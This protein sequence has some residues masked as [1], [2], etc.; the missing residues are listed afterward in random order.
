MHVS[1]IPGLTVADCVVVYDRAAKRLG[2]PLPALKELFSNKHLGNAWYISIADPQSES[3]ETEANAVR[4]RN[5]NGEIVEWEEPVALHDQSEQ[6]PMG[7]LSQ[8]DAI[9]GS[10]IKSSEPNMLKPL[11]SRAKEISSGVPLRS[12]RPSSGEGNYKLGN[13]H[14]KEALNRNS[15]ESNSDESKRFP[16]AE[17]E[18]APQMAEKKSL[19]LPCRPRGGKSDTSYG[20]KST[21][22]DQPMSS[23]PRSSEGQRPEKANHVG[24]KQGGSNSSKTTPADLGMKVRKDDSKKSQLSDPKGFTP[25]RMSIDL[26]AEQSHGSN[27][28][29]HAKTQPKT[30]KD[31]MSDARTLERM[32]ALRSILQVVHSST[33]SGGLD[34]TLVGNVLCLGAVTK[35]KKLGGISLF[36]YLG[37]LCIMH[38]GCLRLLVQAKQETFYE[39]DGSFQAA[40]EKMSSKFL[41][42]EWTKNSQEKRVSPTERVKETTPPYVSRTG[43]VLQLSN[44]L[45]D[46]AVESDV[47]LK[48]PRLIKRWYSTDSC[49]KKVVH[50]AVK[51]MTKWNTFCSGR[52]ENGRCPA[53]E[54][55]MTIV[56]KFVVLELH[57]ASPISS[58]EAYAEKD[59]CIS[60]FEDSSVTL[61]RAI[62]FMYQYVS[63]R[64]SNEAPE[65]QKA[66]A[67]IAQA[68]FCRFKQPFGEEV[69]A[70]SWKALCHAHKPSLEKLQEKNYFWERVVDPALLIEED[71]FLQKDPHLAISFLVALMKN[72]K[73]VR[74]L[75]HTE[76]KH[77]KLLIQILTRILKLF[78]SQPEVFFKKLSDI[79]NSFPKFISVV[80]LSHTILSIGMLLRK[81]LSHDSTVEASFVSA[82]ELAILNCGGLNPLK[83]SLE[84]VGVHAEKSLSALPLPGE[85]APST[86]GLAT[87]CKPKQCAFYFAAFLVSS[88]W[89]GSPD[90]SDDQDAHPFLNALLKKNISQKNLSTLYGSIIRIHDAVRPLTKK[91][92]THRNVACLTNSAD[93]WLPD[94]VNV[95][96]KVREAFL[97]VSSKPPNHTPT[98]TP[99]QP[100]TKSKRF[101]QKET[102][103]PSLK[104]KFIFGEE[105]K[106]F[107]MGSKSLELSSDILKKIEEWERER[108]SAVKCDRSELELVIFELERLA[109]FL[110]SGYEPMEESRRQLPLT[111]NEL[112]RDAKIIFHDEVKTAK[113]EVGS[114]PRKRSSYLGK[115][116]L[117]KERPALFIKRSYPMKGEGLYS[118]EVIKPGSLIGEFYGEVISKQRYAC[119]VHSKRGA[120][121]TCMS[122]GDGLVVNAGVST[123]QMKLINHSCKP[124]AEVKRCVV[125]NEQRLSIFASRQ[126][127]VIEEITVDYRKAQLYTNKSFRCSCQAPNCAGTILVPVP[128]PKK[129]Y[130]EPHEQAKK[131]IVIG[132]HLVRLGDELSK[133]QAEWENIETKKSGVNSSRFYLS[134]TEPNIK[135]LCRLAWAFVRE[136]KDGFII[137]ELHCSKWTGFT[138]SQVEPNRIARTP[139]SAASSRKGLGLRSGQ[140][141]RALSAQKKVWSPREDALTTSTPTA[142][143]PAKRSPR[144]TEGSPRPPSVEPSHTRGNG[145]HKDSQQERGFHQRREGHS[146]LPNL[147]ESYSRDRNYSIPRHSLDR[148]RS[149]DNYYDRPSNHYRDRRANNYYDRRANDYFDRRSSGY[150]ERRSIRYHDRRS[151]GHHENRSNDYYDPRSNVHPRG[152]GPSSGWEAMFDNG[153]PSQGGDRG[154]T[155]GPQREAAARTS[156]PKSHTNGGERDAFREKTDLGQ[157]N[158]PYEDTARES[159]DI[160]ASHDPRRQP[161]PYTSN[162]R[163]PIDSREGGP[164]QQNRDFQQRYQDN[165]G[166]SSHLERAPD[167]NSSPRRHTDGMD[168]Y[169]PERRRTDEF[170]G[171]GRGRGSGRGDY[172]EHYRHGYPR[173]R[174]DSHNPGW[175]R[176]GRGRHR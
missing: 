44:R 103:S 161:L 110:L 171:R 42:T 140:P 38:L 69:Q 47:I 65:S 102:I 154:R 9:H 142:S 87:E 74:K 94:F 170:Y 126:V 174:S 111:A 175:K 173:R 18:E 106:K 32:T 166:Q 160:P 46:A 118:N 31:A 62:H 72:V 28:S 138:Q 49:V 117:Q 81:I 59:L 63:R 76:D 122:L 15:P 88:T 56:S 104:S 164:R 34:L 39:V 41:E 75:V 120:A 78:S 125:N 77:R 137:E 27:E 101:T 155:S 16:G 168:G 64:P 8:D 153:N 36:G 169:D 17:A 127:E 30:A 146:R 85:K 66:F 105:M 82:M 158:R 119:M 3:P 144:G 124:N 132:L 92:A 145:S 162:D 147:P 29:D 54:Q 159:A 172:D 89:N 2:V 141:I 13:A 107:P 79:S 6:K 7:V 67:N 5:A 80:D 165:R 93:S 90:S 133:I 157:T 83:L 116:L 35:N 97:K 148:K 24:E 73:A 115:K 55:A 21:T 100:A 4:V 26:T 135:E 70:R 128:T 71:R 58:A 84:D 57:A 43:W 121:M 51:L 25:P 37:S 114:S 33:E 112:T 136:W 61:P 156:L 52:N 130:R 86:P 14:N 123:S 150:Y 143:W 131:R 91:S 95:A 11:S 151:S 108:L 129:T 19:D 98:L 10:A 96:N 48:T 20:R 152:E 163:S 139:T 149:W 109:E 176:R 50:L 45:F 22:P 23:P 167:S 113:K 60:W 53:F 99:F 68:F 40:T 1:R 134:S 12:V